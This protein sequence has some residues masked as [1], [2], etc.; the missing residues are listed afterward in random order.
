[1]QA[2]LPIDEPDFVALVREGLA[3]EA[4]RLWFRAGCLPLASGHG[5]AEPLPYRQLAADDL[6]ALAR[7]VLRQ[8]FVPSRLADDVTDAAHALPLVAE[9]PGEALLET[10]LVRDDGDLV[11]LIE[12]AR[13][14][15]PEEVM[16]LP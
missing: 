7:V 10:R 3:R 12:I 9:L 11:I 4:D 6:D 2:P 5:W 1:M 14:L 15:P 13:P 16:E 8:G